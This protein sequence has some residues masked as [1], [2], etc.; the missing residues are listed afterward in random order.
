[1]ST[2]SLALSFVAAAVLFALPSDSRSQ[3]CSVGPYTG[4]TSL[5]TIDSAIRGAGNGAVVCLERG[6]AWTSGG[7]AF[8]ISTPHPDSSRVTVCA[9]SGGSCSSAGG[10]NPRIT[11]TS[12]TV[13]VVMFASSGDGYTFKN[14]DFYNTT[15]TGRTAFGSLP[16]GLAN[17]T[18]EGG[19]F[20]GWLRFAD[21]SA[22]GGAP[23]DNIDL[24]ICS[25]RVEFRNAYS[26]GDQH[27]MFGACTNCGFSVY[28]H[29]W[30]QTD[31]GAGRTHEL[32]FSTWNFA[33]KTNNVV[34]ECSHFLTD[35]SGTNG[36]GNIIK[37]ATGSNATI[38]DNIFEMESG[39]P[40]SGANCAGGINFGGHTDSGGGWGWN[41][42]QIYRNTFLMKNCY[43]ITNAIGSDINIYN[44][45]FVHDWKSGDA[46]YYT[47]PFTITGPCAGC[48][49]PERTA[50]YNNTV[51]AS[52]SG[53]SQP[54]ISWDGAGSGH[55]FY[56]NAIYSTG[57]N[58]VA[59]IGI[60][61]CND[62]GAGGADIDNNFVYTPND[63]SPSVGW[64]SCSG[65][66]GNSTSF[67]TNPGLAN[68]TNVSLPAVERFKVNS[69]AAI[70]GRGRSG[71][72]VEDFLR[73]VRGTPP[74]AGALEFGSAT[75]TTL[76]PP[77]LLAP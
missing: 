60:A 4:T 38:R 27:I 34:I 75:A 7:T 49:S 69:G 62:F 46:F 72:P 33:S 6:S 52:E 66:S 47:A 73:V 8:S 65:A 59:V 14:I 24:G 12:S 44:N 77:L 56:N 5:S 19:V 70:L 40:A 31:T 41:G 2:K 50:F 55:K 25:N 53:N 63:S 29:D 22:N 39:E 61:D 20:D 57:A 11:T 71:A 9:S 54:L 35:S 51:F 36:N 16:E 13:N 10:A 67:A 45:L 28:V 32:D 76:A 18:I 15:R 3:T 23:P 58:Q 21:Y 64:T 43:G 37:L 68:P 30:G 42:A 48:S 26:T 17:V 74:S 1:M